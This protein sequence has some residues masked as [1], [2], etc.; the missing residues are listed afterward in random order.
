MEEEGLLLRV[1]Q[2]ERL[3]L[4][5]LLSLDHLLGLVGGGVSLLRLYLG[6]EMAPR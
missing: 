3:R 4:S 5:A 2:G 1:V 6:L